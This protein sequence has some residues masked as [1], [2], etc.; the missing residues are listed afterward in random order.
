MCRWHV[1]GRENISMVRLGELCTQNVWPLNGAEIWRQTRS[2]IPLELIEGCLCNRCLNSSFE[3]LIELWFCTCQ[4]RAGFNACQFPSSGHRSSSA[5]NYSSP[6]ILFC[7]LTPRSVPLLL[8]LPSLLLERS[9][10]W[11]HRKWIRGRRGSWSSD[12]SR[13]WNETYRT[14]STNFPPSPPF[15]PQLRNLM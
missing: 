7:N 11:I 4:N 10:K 12:T 8:L 14:A 3:M 1:K 5:G 13:S 6:G 9:K 15:S 2:L